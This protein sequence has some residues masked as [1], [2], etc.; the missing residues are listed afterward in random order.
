MQ[1]VNNNQE[2]EIEK[3]WQKKQKWMEETRY[4]MYQHKINY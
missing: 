4:N 1:E 2:Q 3:V